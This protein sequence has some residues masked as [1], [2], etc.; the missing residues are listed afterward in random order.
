[1]KQQQSSAPPLVMAEQAGPSGALMTAT[2]GQD[3]DPAGRAVPAAFAGLRWRLL[4]DR[5]PARGHDGKP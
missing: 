1:M 2:A 5:S 3:A 4:P